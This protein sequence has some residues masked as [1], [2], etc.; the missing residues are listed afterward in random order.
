VSAVLGALPVETASNAM[1][2]LWRVAAPLTGRHARALRHLAAAFPE[3]SAAEHEAIARDM[4]EVLGRVF[5]ES[6]HLA[7]LRD[8]DRITID[9][10]AALAHLDAKHAVVVCAAHQGNWEIAAVGLAR[11]GLRSTGVYQ[12]LTNPFVDALVRDM[13]APFYA[14]G[15]FEKSPTTARQLLRY[16]RDGGCVSFLADT[17]ADPGVVVDFF[18]R[19]AASTPFPAMIARTVDAP[20]YVAQVIR[21]PG[22]RFRLTMR[23]VDLPRTKNKEADIATATQNVQTEFERTIRQRPAQWMWAHRRWG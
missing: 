3:K 12:K 13:R 7:A 18:G 22:V 17:R 10:P 14:G 9:D 6:F 21:E 19:P 16:A 8:S 2:G 1:G 20:L 11:L 15:L 4:W 5:A 23:P